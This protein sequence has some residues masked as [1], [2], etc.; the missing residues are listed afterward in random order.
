MVIEQH[1]LWRFFDLWRFF[2]QNVGN[3]RHLVFPRRIENQLLASTKTC[4]ELSD[5]HCCPD[6]HC[7]R[8]MKY[9]LWG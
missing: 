8:K 1:G 9:A 2:A 4:A 6:V 3:S 5:V 7:F